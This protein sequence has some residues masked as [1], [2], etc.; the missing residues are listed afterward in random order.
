MHFTEHRKRA[1]ALEKCPFCL[2]NVPKHLIV[3]MGIKVG[4]CYWVS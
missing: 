1:A 3:A 2:D 4:L